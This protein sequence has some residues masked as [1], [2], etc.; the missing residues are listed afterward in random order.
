MTTVELVLE[1]VCRLVS[2]GLAGMAD[3]TG[4]AERGCRRTTAAAASKRRRARGTLAVYR[5]DGG[6]H[7]LIQSGFSRYMQGSECNPCSHVLRSAHAAEEL[8]TVRLARRWL[9]ALLAFDSFC[10]SPSRFVSIVSSRSSCGSI[11]EPGSLT[12]MGH[13]THGVLPGRDA[14]AWTKACVAIIAASVLLKRSLQTPPSSLA[15]DP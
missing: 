9:A 12:Q 5:S 7:P 11:N 3:H 13:L 15:R 2:M 10:G 4:R 8:A 14:L 6:V 1:G